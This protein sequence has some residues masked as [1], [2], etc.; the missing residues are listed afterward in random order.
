MNLENVHVRRGCG[1]GAVAC[2]LEA[3]VPG[4]HAEPS[5]RTRD[6]GEGRKSATHASTQHKNANPSGGPTYGMYASAKETTTDVKTITPRYADVA[7]ALSMP[8]YVDGGCA[9]A[10]EPCWSVKA[11]FAISVHQELC[12]GRKADVNE[13]KKQRTERVRAAGEALRPA[14]LFVLGSVIGKLM[15]HQG[16]RKAHPLDRD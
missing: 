16:T 4:T 13:G 2:S 12:G 3:V 8:L 10:R 9:A 14:G 15:S 11:R 1:A 5:A 7:S 6:R